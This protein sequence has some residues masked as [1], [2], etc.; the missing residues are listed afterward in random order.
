MPGVEPV[1]AVRPAT[2]PPGTSAPGRIGVGPAANP[3]TVSP[4]ALRRLAQ[5]TRRLKRR[6]ATLLELGPGQRVLDVGCGTGADAAAVGIKVGPAGRAFGIDYDASMIRDA[7]RATA[8]RRA[9]P[10]LLVADGAAMPYRAACFDACYSERVLQHVARPAAVVAEMVRVTRA[11]GRIVIADTDWASLSIDAPDARVERR[12]VGFVAE[13]LRNGYAGRQLRR[14]MRGAGVED[15]HVELWPLVWT[16]YGQFCATS[17]SLLDMHRRAV[18]A[19]AVS[20]AE[21]ARLHRSLIDADRN[22]AFFASGTI[23]V[24][25]GRC[26]AGP[27]AQHPSPQEEEQ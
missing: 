9:V 27:P 8:G 2:P 7:R 4:D 24:A 14:L 11:G 10:C 17:L 26:P 19:G 16:D 25:Y 18:A 3:G 5:L 15:V 6:I 23:V 1:I 13:S 22:G 21:L 12:L 20:R